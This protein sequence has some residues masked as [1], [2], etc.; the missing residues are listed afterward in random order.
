MALLGGGDDTRGPVLGTVFLFVVE[1]LLW[2]NAPLAYM[3]ILGGILA[4]FVLLA[5][6]GLVG[7]I[8]ARRKGVGA[9]A[10]TASTAAPGSAPA[11]ASLGSAPTQEP[12]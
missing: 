11:A 7:M 8:D 1:E 10:A 12:T 4:G 3:I 6:N 9:G 2:A 5:P